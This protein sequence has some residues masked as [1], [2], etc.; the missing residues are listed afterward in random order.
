MYSLFLYSTSVIFTFLL[1]S[2]NITLS[3]L[4]KSGIIILSGINSSISSIFSLFTNSDSFLLKPIRLDSFD[5]FIDLK[6]FK[7]FIILYIK[8][9]FIINDPLFKL[10]FN[11]RTLIRNSIKRQFT[12][13]SKKTQEILDCSFEEFKIYLEEQFDENMNWNNK[14]SY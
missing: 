2:F 6:Y 8:I 12:E 11:I 4:K 1:L 5:S 14:G 13:K 10:C 9:I 3:P 7:Y